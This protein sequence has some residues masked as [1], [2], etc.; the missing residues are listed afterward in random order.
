MVK[1]SSLQSQE[2]CCEGLQPDQVVEDKGR[3]GVMGAIV[4]RGDL[5]T[6]IYVKVKKGNLKVSL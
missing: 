3:C 4:E 5:Q 6:Q 2:H 1:L